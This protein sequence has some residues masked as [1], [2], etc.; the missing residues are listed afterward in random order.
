MQ[1]DHRHL[2]YF[3]ITKMKNLLTNNVQLIVAAFL[4]G[5]LVYWWY[6]FEFIDKT[7]GKGVIGIIAML[8]GGFVICNLI[9]GYIF[10]LVNRAE[11]V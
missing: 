11:K 3:P 7:S 5:M 8:L 4:W 2:S 1:G 9:V 10:G 6:P